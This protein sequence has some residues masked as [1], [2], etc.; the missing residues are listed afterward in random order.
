[1]LATG[2]LITPDL[3]PA[4]L[5]ERQN[6]LG[7]SEAAVALGISPYAAPIDLWIEKTTGR[8]QIVQT[9]AMEWGKILEPVI[10][11]KYEERTDFRVVDHQL[12]AR[13]ASCPWMTATLDGIA[14]YPDHNRVV[15]VKTA[16]VYADGWGPDGSDQIPDPYRVQV[17]HQ[18]AIVGF[19]CAD[20]VALIGGQE[21]RIFHI[22]RDEAL[23][24]T[25]REGEALFWQHVRDGTP[26]TYGTM[27][28]RILALLNPEC[29]G[30]VELSGEL[31]YKLD[32]YEE[33]GGRIK[34][35]E[36]TREDIK[37]EILRVLGNH[38]YGTVC[39][40]NRVQR[41]LTESKE[42]TVPPSRRHYIKLMKEKTK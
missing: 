17:M 30:S 18:M 42:Y 37:I 12:F 36:A 19:R 3:E 39:G 35:D 28:P 26:P 24:Q 16:S 38:R 8:R 7:G 40:K 6:S 33:L 41:F 4:W 27:D 21:L 11:A 15:E 10:L 25:I 14:R 2:T 34:N 23:I 20:V 13:D 29:Y 22:E 31:A 9:E 5:A 32:R 1:M